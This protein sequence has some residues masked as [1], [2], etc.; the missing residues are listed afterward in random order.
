[1]RRLSRH[2]SIE[3]LDSFDG[4]LITDHS[5]LGRRY[6]VRG[7]GELVSWL[8]HKRDNSSPGE[9]VDI[10][11]SVGGEEVLWHGEAP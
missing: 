11:I 7:W 1:M 8:V 10:E 9:K 4:Y 2:I 3:P 6:E 5:N